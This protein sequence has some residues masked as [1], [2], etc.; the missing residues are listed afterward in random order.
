MGKPVERQNFSLSFFLLASLIAVCTA[1][2]FYDEFLGRR[3]WKDFQGNQGAGHA[4]PLTA[5]TGHFW[6]FGPDNVEVV[7]KV[8]DGREVNGH[9]WVFFGALSSVEYTLT[10]TDVQTG[11]V[12]T[13]RNPSGKLASAAYTDAF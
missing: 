5:D 13:Y 2:S 6:F 7:L 9:F 1:W 8:L 4:V 3:P 10:V 11:E 12:R